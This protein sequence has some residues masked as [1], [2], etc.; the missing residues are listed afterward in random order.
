VR[1]RRPAADPVVIRILLADDQP[2]VRAGFGA[3]LAAEDDFEIVGEAADGERAVAETQR[4]RPD[5]VLMDVRMPHLDGLH[6]TARITADPALAET[7]VVVLT[8]FEL[9]DYVFGALKAGAA[10]FLLKDIEPLVLIAAVRTIHR[11]EA[12]LAPRITQQLIAAFIAAGPRSAQTETAAL[13]PLTDRER[14][15]L[16]LVG[17]GLSNTQIAARLVISPLTAKTHVSRL[18]TKLDAR[19]RAQLVV[20]AYETGLVTARTVR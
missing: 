20:L 3:V 8:T 9:D 2:L 17:T 19:D 13:D 14:Q 12:L 4:L 11:G 10:G 1:A 7:R 15:V 16:A 5:V 18:F 6:A